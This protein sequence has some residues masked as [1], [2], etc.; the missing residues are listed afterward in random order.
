MAAVSAS[1]PPPSSSSFA[2]SSMGLDSGDKV[3]H[4]LARGGHSNRQ[5]GNPSRTAPK[6]TGKKPS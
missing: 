5:T 1:P 4:V 3:P 6:K 2:A